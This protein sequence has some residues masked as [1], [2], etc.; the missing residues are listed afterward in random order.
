[1]R[2]RLVLFLIISAVL[3]GCS[4]ADNISSG[5][6]TEEEAADN[7]LEGLWLDFKQNMPQDRNAEEDFK[8]SDF[9]AE[10]K[11]YLNKKESML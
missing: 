4:Q 9:I 2:I 5:T 10:F 11:K 1:M 3:C 6:N 8:S 7:S